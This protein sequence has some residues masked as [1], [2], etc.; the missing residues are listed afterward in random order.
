MHDS[1]DVSELGSSLDEEGFN[2]YEFHLDEEHLRDIERR[3]EEGKT[4]NQHLGERFERGIEKE[5]DYLQMTSRYAIDYENLGD[6]M[7]QVYELYLDTYCKEGRMT[8]S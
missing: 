5:F 4:I 3:L 6:Y 7:Q 2:R 8:R 1:A